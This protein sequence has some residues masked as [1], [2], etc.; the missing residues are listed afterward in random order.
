MGEPQALTDL[1]FAILRVLWDR[2]SAT[3]AEIT[4]TLRASRGLAQQTIATILTRLEKRG[5][6]QHE[7]RQ[8][9]YL[10][11]AIVS[12]PDVRNTML[13]DLTDRVF[14]G[15]VAALVSQLLSAREMSAGDLARVKALI[16]THEA[17]RGSSHD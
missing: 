2:G 3:A 7:V 1:Q 10:F 16:A 5:I 6:V 8:R 4:D 14:E 9:Q 17:T 11:R 12:E 15:D 13:T